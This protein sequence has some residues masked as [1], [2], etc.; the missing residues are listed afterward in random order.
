MILAVMTRATLGHAG[1][2]LEADAIT[3]AIFALIT[4][5][6]LTRVAAPLLAGGYTELMQASALLWLGAFALFLLKFGP[7][8]F[9]PRAGVAR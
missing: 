3:Q 2:A 5:A 4:A 1:R 9:K 6:A 7:I 8:L